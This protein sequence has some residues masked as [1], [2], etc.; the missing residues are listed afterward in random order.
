MI[1]AITKRVAPKD[2]EG[3]EGETEE[4]EESRARGINPTID[5]FLDDGEVKSITVW[6]E[7]GGAE[8]L[9]KVNGP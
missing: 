3:Y 9:E 6:Y 8:T 1:R 4:C 5:A 7:D 2:E